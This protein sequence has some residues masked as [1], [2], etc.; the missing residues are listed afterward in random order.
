[1]QHDSIISDSNLATLLEFWFPF[2]DIDHTRQL[3]TWCDGIPLLKVKQIDRVTFM[4]S[5]VGYFPQQLA[6]FE[7]EWNFQ[8]RRDSRP[9]S[10]ILR[11]G[12]IIHTNK[13]SDRYDRHPE[14]I[15]A[16]RPTVNSDWMIAV[17]L[18]ESD[19]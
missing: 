3:G 15:F 11:L 8:H 4:L 6:P 13:Q 14:R 19:T 1:M 9:Q 16:S 5:G 12:N 2:S 10:V 7:T 17:E 18:S